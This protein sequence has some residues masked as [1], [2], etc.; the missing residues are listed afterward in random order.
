MSK[1]YDVSMVPAVV[2]LTN[3]TEDTIAIE[4]IPFGT[5]EILAGDSIKLT[6]NDSEY[7]LVTML[8]ARD[9]DLAISI[10]GASEPTPAP[11]SVDPIPEPEEPETVIDN[12]DEESGEDTNPEEPVDEEII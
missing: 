12:P 1:V 6:I 11:L 10:E 8:K 3:N 2:T 4:L 9:L 7:L 5:Q